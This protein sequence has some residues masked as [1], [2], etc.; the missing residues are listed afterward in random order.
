M[1]EEKKKKYVPSVY[2]NLR[3][4]FIKVPEEIYRCSGINIFEKR[5]KSLLFTT[6]L[7]IIRNTNADCIMAVYPYTPQITI[8][9]SI[10]STASV[11]C[12]IGVGGGTTKGARTRF[13]ALH[14]E[15]AGAYGVVVNGPIPNEDIEGMSKYL[16]IPVIATITSLNNDIKGKVDAGASILNVSGA[17]E[18]PNM[19]REIRKIVGNEFPIIAT[20]GNK[21]ESI[22]AT[23]DAGANAI[24]YTAPSSSEVFAEMMDRYRH[25]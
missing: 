7:A 23:I 22:K 10:I 6:D 16:D 18:T 12:L 1:T 21:P 19:V 20:G 3:K 15:L 11:P 17:K 4:E 8:S 5:I 9:D 13:L 2:S 14:A 25:E 24:T